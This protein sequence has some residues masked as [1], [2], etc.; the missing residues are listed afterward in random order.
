[1]GALHHFFESPYLL[2]TSDAVCWV[3]AEGYVT[4]GNPAFRA[5]YGN[6]LRVGQSR[7]ISP[8]E[9]FSSKSVATMRFA[10]SLALRGQENRGIRCQTVHRTDVMISLTPVRDTAVDL[11]L[12]VYVTFREQATSAHA[13]LDRRLTVL[14]ETARIGDW[15]WSLDDDEFFVSDIAY[16]LFALDEHRFFG[17]KRSFMHCLSASE[18]VLVSAAFEAA[19]AMQTCEIEFCVV[20]HDG[21][22]CW[23]RLLGKRVDSENGSPRAVY[24]TVQDISQSKIDMQDI[25]A[26]KTE[27]LSLYA[28]EM[29]E[30]QEIQQTLLRTG[31]MLRY[32]EELAHVGTLEYTVDGNIHCSAG[33]YRIFGCADTEMTMERLLMCI[34]EEDRLAMLEKMRDTNESLVHDAVYRVVRP[35]GEIRFVTFQSHWIDQTDSEI[36][37]IYVLHDVTERHQSEE[38]L[39][40]SLSL[41][42][43]RE[44]SLAIAELAA[45]IAQEI[46]NPLIA[47]QG[48]TQLLQL[49]ASVRQNQYLDMML[50]EFSRIEQSVTELLTSAK[51]LVGHPVAEPCESNADDVK[52]G[53]SGQSGAEVRSQ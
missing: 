31:R 48:F 13:D 29:R 22:T 23:L 19:V 32:V 46:R 15:R 50:S 21:T 45:G 34:H 11:V 33:I 1:M 24:G 26:R 47:L 16:R 44:K 30:R 14:Q 53:V 2:S 3:D 38:H 52:I 36:H 37:A 49:E 27:Y 4:D 51:P 39:K 5:L 35:S 28:N 10:I 42:S 18:R 25:A 43:K 40:R 20:Q 17:T 12:G 41:L 6:Q 7:N 9:F 8:T